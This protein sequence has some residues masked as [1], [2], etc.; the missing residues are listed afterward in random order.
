VLKKAEMFRKEP[1]Y[2]SISPSFS[3]LVD[4]DP[5]HVDVDGRFD[6]DPG[7]GRMGSVCHVRLQGSDDATTVE[8]VLRTEV[9]IGVPATVLFPAGVTLS[10]AVR[11]TLHLTCNESWTQGDSE[12]ETGVSD[13]DMTMASRFY[14][15]FPDSWAAA[16]RSYFDA[17]SLQQ[18][19]GGEVFLLGIEI[20]EVGIGSKIDDALVQEGSTRTLEIDVAPPRGHADELPVIVGLEDRIRVYTNDVSYDVTYANSWT[21]DA[22][23]LQSL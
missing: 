23:E 14:L 7:T 11:V 6:Y 12:D 21:L 15:R 1:P 20:G 19:V 9:L 3:H 17:V 10:G 4:E 22:V 18:N 2:L 5:D 13:W 8:A 16:S